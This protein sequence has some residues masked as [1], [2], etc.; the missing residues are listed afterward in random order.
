[1]LISGEVKDFQTFRFSMLHVSFCC[2]Y[3]ELLYK[4]INNEME[5]ALMLAINQRASSPLPFFLLKL[6]LLIVLRD[7]QVVSQVNLGF[8]CNSLYIFT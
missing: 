4:K 7:T 3:G 1:M 8:P 5:I 6:P 2:R